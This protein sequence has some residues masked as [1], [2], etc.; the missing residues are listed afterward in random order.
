M[1][2]DTAVV[3]TSETP[4]PESGEGEKQTVKPDDSV[5]PE[6]RA[7][8]KKANKEAETLRLKL[9]QFE[10][11]QKS[12]A[13]KLAERAEQAERER[14]ALRVESLRARVAIAKGL[15][16]DLMEFLTADDEDELN[17]QAD[18][19]MARLAPADPARPRADIDQ[20]ARPGPLA[21]NGDPLLD[22]L[23]NKLGIR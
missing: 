8:L 7:A 11:A 1:A 20:G 23:K 21:L 12:E 5:P 14:D 2:D 3:H 9:Q 13:Q 16:A 6:V 17:A 4:A 19:L 18:R 22:S 15:P 10:D